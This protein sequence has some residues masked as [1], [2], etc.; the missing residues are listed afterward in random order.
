MPFFEREKGG[1]K[2]E[3]ESAKVQQIRG[4]CAKINAFDGTYLVW[5]TFETFKIVIS[6]FCTGAQKSNLARGMCL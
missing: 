5:N 6:D 2:A 3:R 4:E 1:G